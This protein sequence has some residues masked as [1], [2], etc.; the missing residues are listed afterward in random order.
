MRRGLGLLVA[1]LLLGGML[2]RA[3]AQ[4]QHFIIGGGG[5]FAT[6]F[7]PR[8]DLGRGTNLEGFLGFRVNDQVTLEVSVDFTSVT[9]V[10]TEAGN[11]VDETDPAVVGQYKLDQNRY[12]IDGTIYYH[13]GRRKPFHPYIFGAGGAERRENTI[14]T[15]EGEIGKETDHDPT[16]SFG[17]GFDYYVLYNVAV[18][19]DVR[20][21]LPGFGTDSRTRRFFFGVGYYF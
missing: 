13:F 21:W 10:F 19:T 20:W 3:D 12:H 1:T 6:L 8:L 16:I 4:E 11:I 5:G 2:G 9:R 14:T 18:R 7:D 15:F 17:A